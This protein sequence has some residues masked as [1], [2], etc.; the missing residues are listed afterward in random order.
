MPLIA[1]A[2][3]AYAA[4]LLSGFGGAFVWTAAAALFVVWRGARSR[5]ERLALLAVVT[6]G[7]ATAVATRAADA[8]CAARLR[9]SRS[10]QLELGADARPGAFIPARHAC[11]MTVRVSVAKGQ[12]D[13]GALVEVRGAVSQSRGG[14]L[15]ERGIIRPLRPPG[16][17][18]RWRAALGRGIDLHFGADAPLV[19]ALLIADMQE[20]SPALRRR[21]AA[22]GLSHMLS[23]SG[24]H[25]GL[26]AMAVALLAQM[27]GLSRGR[28][29]VLVVGLTT[30]YVATIGAPLP[31]V[32]AAAMLGAISLTQ[33]LQRP[34][35]PW[36]VLAIGALLPL[37]DAR[38]VL[39]VGYQLSVVGIVALIA[40]GALGKRWP[41]LGQ[42]GGRGALYR[43]LVA[44][45]AATLLTAP[46]VAATFGRLSLVA[47]V[48]NLAAVP[49]IA[50]L[51]PMLFLALLTFPVGALAQ[52]V[53]DACHPLIVAIDWLAA[54]AADLPGASIEVVAD[55]GTTAL[56]SAAGAAFV[57]AA[58]SR[59]PGRWLVAGTLCGALVAWRPLLPDRAPATELHMIDVGQGDA[60]ALRTTRGHWVLFDAGRDW[61][62][63]DEGQRDVVPYLAAR[64]GRLSAFVLSH[65]HAD[66]VGGATSTL[67]ALRPTWYFDPG[68]A[69][70]TTPYR[71]SLDEARRRGIRWR[72]VRPGDSLAVDEAVIS[73]L[74]PDS[75]WAAGQT[76]PNLAS[77]IARIRVGDVV[78]LMTGDAEAPEERWL[79]AHQP[80]LRA[81]VLKVAHHGSR[82]SSSDAFLDAVRPRLALVSVG[83]GNMYRHPSA[84]I[85]ESLAAHG[86]ITMRT[87]RH[88]SIV[89]RTDGHA[90]EVESGGERFALR[91]RAAG[92]RE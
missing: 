9:G 80:D 41:W 50:V 69:G 19:R 48:T 28:S 86:A 82:T 49:V 34:T 30:V 56:A 66:H 91:P 78:F 33:V 57:V 5:R 74:A 42:G 81:D 10:L 2:T 65:P 1:S 26:I 20:L 37:V 3:L 55:P 67:R 51:Q 70:G 64:G 8:G 44:S 32:R 58:M 6:A 27:A 15:V 29:A 13:A 14:L 38:A 36:A 73:F 92:S 59:H 72:R 24:L 16:L 22:A 68:Y 25:V 54:R 83:E 31:A 47:P 75:A 77:T 79:L 89:V 4:G 87:D 23:V 39:D 90:I 63:G 11:G 35:S 43:A 7:I 76:D 84:E 40:A 52:F 85:I 46:L 53:A 62:G 21:F 18:T 17:L 12:A 45:T 71:T 60:I 88:G 61:Q